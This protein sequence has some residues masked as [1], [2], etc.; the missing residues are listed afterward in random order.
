MLE[1]E[2]TGLNPSVAALIP[3]RDFTRN[4]EL[5]DTNWV[6]EK[7]TDA[8]YSQEGRWGYT[9]GRYL[10]NAEQNNGTY[11]NDA[12][13]KPIRLKNVFEGDLAYGWKNAKYGFLSFEG[14]GR[15]YTEFEVPQ[16]GWY[17]VQ[18]YGFIQSDN[19]DAYIF[20]KVKGS[21]SNSIEGGESK[22][23]LVR[24]PSGTFPSKNTKANCLK[25]GEALTR[26]DK[27]KESYK[28]TVWILV[29]E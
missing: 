11:P 1:E 7:K 28:N 25:V 24:V 17:M 23:N 16:P 26:P 20:A 5:F 10:D 4:A 19:N 29:T 3:D 9:F 22:N 6:M 13:N 21:T 14:V 27:D 12:W 8:D 15:T 2:V 18:C